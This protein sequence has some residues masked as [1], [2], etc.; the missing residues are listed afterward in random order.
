M[1][2]ET[3]NAVLERALPH[4]ELRDLM[5][6]VIGIGHY[7]DTMPCPLLVFSGPPATGKTTIATAL[8]F[9]L[10]TMVV[11]RVPELRPAHFTVATVNRVPDDTTAPVVPFIVEM[12]HADMDHRLADRLSG[13]DVRAAIVSWAFEG[14]VKARQTTR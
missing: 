13:P 2:N 10:G 9:A 7:A 3:W 5:Q 12:P 8:R 11:E 1:T 14:Y 4:A 6:R